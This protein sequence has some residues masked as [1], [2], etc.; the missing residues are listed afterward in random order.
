MVVGTPVGNG[1]LDGFWL[2]FLGE[3]A[4]GESAD[5]FVGGEAEGD[6]LPDGE[7]VDVLELVCGDE[8]CEPEALLEAN[9]P[10]LQFQIVHAAL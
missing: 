2:E 10:I 5:F 6:E 9:E 4:V 1:L 7:L 3:G 8:G